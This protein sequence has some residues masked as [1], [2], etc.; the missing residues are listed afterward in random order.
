MKKKVLKNNKRGQ[1]DEMNVKRS[2][3][4]ENNFS[5]ITNNSFSIKNQGKRRNEEE[6]EEEE[7]VIEMTFTKELVFENK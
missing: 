3:E 6:K 4:L 7:K 5:T 2:M 1:S